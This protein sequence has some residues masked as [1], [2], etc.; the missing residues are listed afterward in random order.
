MKGGKRPFDRGKRVEC[1][2][3]ANFHSVF[4]SNLSRRVSKQSLWEAFNACGRVVD[5]YINFHSQNQHT[6]AFVIYKWEED[7]RNVIVE[8]N[9]KV[10]DALSIRVKKVFSGRRV[11]MVRRRAVVSES[12]NA[13]EEGKAKECSSY[14]EALVGSTGSPEVAASQERLKKI[15]KLDEGLCK[16]QINDEI[17]EFSFNLE[18]PEKEMIWLENTVIGRLKELSQFGK[19]RETLE[20]IGIKCQVS[21]ICGVSCCLI[22]ESS[23]DMKSFLDRDQVVAIHFLKNFMFGIDSCVT[24]G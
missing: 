17:V 5:V 14:K 4:I 19:I 1:D 23:N 2:W 24:E 6:F 8:G 9:N 12:K 22:F 11:N 3:R 10:I 7:S 18:V 13:F 16:K 21:H 20:E 15:R